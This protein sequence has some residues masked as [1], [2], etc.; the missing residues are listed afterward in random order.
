VQMFTQQVEKRCA[1]IDLSLH[2]ASIDNP[3]HRGL[4]LTQQAV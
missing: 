4:R 3:P 1:D 2:F